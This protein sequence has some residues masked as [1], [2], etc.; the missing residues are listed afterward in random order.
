VSLI[1]DTLENDTCFPRLRDSLTNPPC[2]PSPSLVVHA[3][4]LAASFAKS[5]LPE[6]EAVPFIASATTLKPT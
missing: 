1:Y 6:C 4:L 5:M 2:H 3:E